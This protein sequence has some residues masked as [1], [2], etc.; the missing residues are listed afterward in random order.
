MR[1]HGGKAKAAPRVIEH[2]TDRFEFENYHTYLEPFIG[3][4]NVFCKVAS[5]FPN[6]IGS[7]AMLDVVLLWQAATNGW[8]PP[9]TLSEEE[10]KS[11]RNAEPSA[12]RAYAGFGVSF[13]G[14]FFGGYARSQNGY[15][16]AGAAHRAI[17]AKAESMK[18]ANTTFIHCD[19]KDHN[20][21]DG[22]FVYCDPPYRGTTPYKWVKDYGFDVN[23]FDATV[24]SWVRNG[25]TVVV[26]ESS[27][28]SN[29]ELLAEWQQRATLEKSGNSGLRTE[30][31]FVVQT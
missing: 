14:K 31:L 13:G 11:L 21:T 6:A 10:Y 7:D 28:P 24:E 15:D 18:D 3:S 2:M 9:E 30:K 17:I 4:A 12:L 26:S 23:E 8:I 27:A 1:Y 5:M 19:Y 22:Y 16:H 25:A 20:P 29:W